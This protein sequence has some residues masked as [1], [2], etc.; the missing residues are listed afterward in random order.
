M[1]PLLAA[2]IAVGVNASAAILAHVAPRS[3]SRMPTIAG[4]V[5]TVGAAALCAIPVLIHGQYPSLILG[6]L[7]FKADA[8]AATMMLPLALAVGATALGLP[9]KMASPRAMVAISAALAA[10][11]LAT[12]ADNT[13]TLLLAELAG[14]LAI[15][16]G[17]D[18]TR[19]AGRSV[20]AL[21]GLFAL[22][23]GGLA[24][25][26]HSLLDTFSVGTSLP[27]AMLLLMAVVTR[28]GALPMQSGLTRTLA[29]RTDASG[30]LLVAPIGGVTVLIRL[31]QPTLA[32][33]PEATA[34]VV[35]GLAGAALAA[36][37]AIAA[38]DLGRS[39]AWTVAALHG[40]MLAGTLDGAQTGSLGG[41]LLWAA[42]I[43]SEVGFILAIAMVTRRLGPVDLRNLHG[44]HTAAPRLSLGFLLMALSIAGLPGTL[45]FVA[46]DVLLNGATS[47][48]ILATLLTVVT[49]A[50]VGFNALRLTFCVFYGPAA[51]EGVDMDIRPRERVALMA[52]VAV[53]LLGGIAPSL[54]PLVASTARAAGH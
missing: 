17:L 31:V 21:S 51:S 54:L 1:N 3:E 27:V 6:P 23:A 20:L 38:Q 45:E 8:L 49:L 14:G 47:G 15:A 36:L 40:L 29:G 41:E 46:E 10:A 22:A 12:V 30:V 53:V 52:L 48:G 11:I 19:R 43:L 32:A 26:Q 7:A 24:I 35:A 39:A 44:L 28:M 5:I 25:A 4:A 16:H 42:L 34:L 9:R 13:L 50:A 37:M 18:D 2:L 33:V